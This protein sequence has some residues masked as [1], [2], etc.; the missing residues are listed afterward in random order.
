MNV[1]A[2]VVLL[3]I[4]AEVRVGLVPLSA[5]IPRGSALLSKLVQ[6]AIR[7]THSRQKHR[8]PSTRGT[9]R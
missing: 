7:I 6:F 9:D 1:I 5:L 8:S 2:V 3:F 4:R